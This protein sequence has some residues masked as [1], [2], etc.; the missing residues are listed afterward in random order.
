MRHGGD[1]L[2]RGISRWKMPLIFLFLLTH[3]QN[4]QEVLRRLRLS[5]AQVRVWLCRHR[6]KGQPTYVCF[7]WTVIQWG[8][9]FFL[10]V[11]VCVCVHTSVRACAAERSWRSEVM[12]GGQIS[13]CSRSQRHSSEPHEEVC[14]CQCVCVFCGSVHMFA[15]ICAYEVGCARAWVSVEERARVRACVRKRRRQ[16][17]IEESVGGDEVILPVHQSVCAWVCVWK[18]SVGKLK[19]PYYT[20][21]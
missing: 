12:V 18:R 1:T 11:C 7:F 20:F 13:Q 17:R 15:W 10:T 19:V 9:G 8:G 4:T 14:L 2:M 3:I 16:N 21:L 5:W 6:Y